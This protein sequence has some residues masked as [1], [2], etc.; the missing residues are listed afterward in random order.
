MSKKRRLVI[1]IILIFAALIVAEAETLQPSTTQAWDRYYQW[2]DAK[3]RS[4]VQD[5]TKFLIQERLSPKELREIQRHFKN[6]EAYVER[7]RNVIPDKE[8]F[9]CPDGEIH[10]WWG[11]ILVPKVKMPQL[12]AFLK[13][14]DHHAGKFSDVVESELKSK[15]GEHFIFRL[16]LMRSKSFVTAHYNTIQETTFYPLDAKRVWSKSIATSIVELKDGKELPPGKDHGFLRRLVSWWRFQE[17]DEGV[18]VE[19]DSASLSRDIP[20][21]FSLPGVMSYIRSTPKETLTSILVSI[22]K[23]FT[24]P[25]GNGDKKKT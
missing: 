18:I 9:S 25:D 16:Q 2:A 15:D 14:Y 4:E 6:G 1:C 20:W 17:T 21:Y 3:V 23:Q 10:H 19:I 12:M 8:K 5:S 22:R 24:T 11:T 13:D 7:A